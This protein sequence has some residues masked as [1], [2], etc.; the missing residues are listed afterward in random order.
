MCCHLVAYSYLLN[1]R[2]ERSLLDQ[3]SLFPPD[4]WHLVLISVAVWVVV[5]VVMTVAVV[6]VISV[7]EP[8]S[9]TVFVAAHAIES[10]LKMWHNNLKRFYSNNFIH[11]SCDSY[12]LSVCWNKLNNFRWLPCTLYE[13]KKKKYRLLIK[14]LKVGDRKN[15]CYQSVN[16]AV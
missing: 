8:V 11:V 5:V 9:G 16:D 2:T 13:T 1:D 4:D 3:G 10:L 15:R 12:L 7:D 6:T 14:E